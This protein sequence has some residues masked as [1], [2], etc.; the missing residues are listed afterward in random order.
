[1]SDYALLF[2]HLSEKLRQIRATMQNGEVIPL[3]SE[4]ATQL[5]YIKNSE[6]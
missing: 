4:L 5:K 1:M 3:P 2:P 6:S